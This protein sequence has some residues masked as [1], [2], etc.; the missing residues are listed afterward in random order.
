MNQSA[1]VSMLFRLANIS[2]SA[3]TLTC[4]QREI[5]RWAM[6]IVAFRPVGTACRGFSEGAVVHA[7][8]LLV[9]AENSSVC[10]SN[11][12]VCNLKENGK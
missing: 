7:L 2:P 5:T 10:L 3:P 6:G 9:Q 1:A 12:P 8:R 11:A 4:E